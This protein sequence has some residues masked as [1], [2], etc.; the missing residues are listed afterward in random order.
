[1][2]DLENDIFS[3]V[4]TELRAQFSGVQVY[5]E[6]VE[7][8][9]RFPAVTIVEADN[10]VLTRMRTENIEN[11]VS[12]MFEINVYSNKASGKKAEAKA[13]EAVHEAVAQGGDVPTLKQRTEIKTQTILANILD[14]D[15][16]IETL[17]HLTTKELRTMCR[18]RKIKFYVTEPKVELAK[19]LV[20][21][22]PS[23]VV[24]P[25]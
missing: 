5:G 9:A 10:R 20:A 2:I 12:S 4:A 6:Y 25:E 18:R 17:T 13:I 21:Y 8:P 22:D 7:T 1:M 23:V 16:K 14:A 15:T 3:A 11:A 19:K 24:A